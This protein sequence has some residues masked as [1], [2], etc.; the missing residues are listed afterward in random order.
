MQ[1]TKATALSLTGLAAHANTL[2]AAMAAVGMEYLN[3]TTAVTVPSSPA[4]NSSLLRPVAEW[5]LWLGRGFN[6]TSNFSTAR[7]LLSNVDLV[8]GGSAG[9]LHVLV[10]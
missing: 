9:R 5:F 6:E 7:L 10:H 3:F 4:Y 1:S 8:E 2:T